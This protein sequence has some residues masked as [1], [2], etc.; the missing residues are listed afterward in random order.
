[1]QPTRRLLTATAA[2]VTVAG[3][4]GPPAAAQGPQLLPAGDLPKLYLAPREPQ[5]SI[6]L[7]AVGRGSSAF[8]DGVEWEAT[9]G[10][11]IPFMRF[12]TDGRGRSVFLGVQAG[13]FGRFSFETTKRDL[14]S[15]DWIFAA[16]VY[17]VTGRH[18]IRL[19]YRHISSHLGDD[20]ISRFE[21]DPEGYLRD[22]VGLV[23]Y[24]QV[25][26]ALGVYGG[27]NVAF[28]VDPNENKRFAL[29]GGFEVNTRA[30]NPTP[31]YG[32]VDVYVDQD[33]S[34]H[35]RV[36]AHVGTRILDERT[37]SL[38]FVTEL[39]VGPSP[40]GEFR[41]RNV[42]LLTVGLVVEI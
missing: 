27:A 31:F 14:I 42:T 10:H 26:G 22:D 29:E 3:V 17:V 34:W 25:S 12:W 37:H 7:I 40:Q 23:G 5:M 20:Y 38:R 6:R 2:I 18:W 28:N 32:G 8:D 36:N 24:A 16:P 19:R 35:P 15:S 11:G 30:V 33:T 13:V 9:F 39:L 21:V 41:R 1:M 4:T